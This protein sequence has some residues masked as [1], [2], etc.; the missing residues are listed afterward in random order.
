MSVLRRAISTTVALAL[1]CLAL[2]PAPAVAGKV[3]PPC[4]AVLGEGQSSCPDPKEP[5]L[6]GYCDPPPGCDPKKSSTV[7]ACSQLTPCSCA[8]LPGMIV[9]TASDGS[10]FCV[11]EKTPEECPRI[12]IANP[13]L[14]NPKC[15]AFPITPRRAVDPNVKSGT[16]G[17]DAAGYVP[18][19]TPL[20]YVVQFEN[21]PSANAAAQI[22]VITDQ[23]DAQKVDLGSFAFGPITFGKYTLVPP[24]AS[25]AFK[26]ALDLTPAQPL[27]VSVDARL[28]RA[29]GLVTW[30]FMSLDPATMQLTEDPDAGLLPPNTSPPAGEGSVL[31][32]VLPQTGLP[33]NTVI[34]NRASIVFDTNAA[35][36][37]PVFV[38]TL[39]KDAPQT[40]VGALAATQAGASFPVQWSG[41]DAGSGIASYTIYVS[42]NGGPFGV[43]LDNTTTV[44]SIYPG[45]AGHGY[46][47]FAIGKD[48]VGNTEPM[49]TVAEAT[50]HAGSGT[51]P[52]CASNVTAGVQVTRSGY[53]YN[54]ATRRFVQ[55]VTLK[56][57]GASAIA[58]PISL[59]LDALASNAA[60]FN[61]SGRT[62][63]ATPAGAPFVNYAGALARGASVT[64]TL[65]FT[66]PSRAGI[67][68]TP[69]VLAG[70]TPR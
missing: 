20:N 10:P 33:T 31:F 48:R 59:V 26:G 61:E 70:T 24:P 29:T 46:A 43:W 66:N 22:V 68:Y 67:T 49:K 8:S 12:P 15:R 45:Q 1:A 69:R 7:G 53:A 60:L 34:A 23:L 17:T 44:A 25:Q 13:V 62:S 9:V 58:G 39:D 50:T 63:C 54:F 65:Q 6:P 64:I 2:P 40:R 36:E 30:S 4:S 55:T 18:G 41:V 56:N 38:N 28:D 27:I 51:P 42:D 47:F 35:I 19:A 16:L 11:P 5:V 3:K 57:A 32:D 52:A 37:T 14:N 21:L